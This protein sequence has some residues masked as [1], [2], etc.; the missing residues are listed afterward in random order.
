MEADI[1]YTKAI[2]WAAENGIIKGY[3]DGT[4]GPNDDITREQLATML[5]RYADSIDMDMS[6]GENTN[7]LSFTDAESVSEYAMAAMQWACGEGLI[8]GMGDN[9]LAPLNNAKRCEVAAVIMRF[10][11]LGK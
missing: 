8:V 7:I 6:A 10:C 2:L 3:G 5:Y 11:E 1:W 9:M 4:F